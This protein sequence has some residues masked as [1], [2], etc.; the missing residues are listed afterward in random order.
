MPDAAVD[1]MFANLQFGSLTFSHSAIQASQHS[2][3]ARQQTPMSE[4]AQPQKEAA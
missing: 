3:Q 4:L 1:E 2:E